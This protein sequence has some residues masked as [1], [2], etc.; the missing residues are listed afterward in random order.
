MSDSTPFSALIH[1][2]ISHP[3][4]CVSFPL[5]VVPTLASSIPL[6][7]PLL[8]SQH[9]PLSLSTVSVDPCKPSTSHA[10]VDPIHPS[11]RPLGNGVT[12][13][14]HNENC[15]SLNFAVDACLLLDA[16]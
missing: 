2:G 10:R 3:S 14:P 8:L 9:L 4:R 11:V 13:T 16:L 12:A 6:P 15:R 1:L 5:F 7:R